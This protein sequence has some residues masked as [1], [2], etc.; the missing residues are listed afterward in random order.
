MN[1][2]ERDIRVIKDIAL[3]HVLSRDQLL[4]LGYF[5]SVS[6]CNRRMAWLASEGFVNVLTTPFFSQHLYAH[7]PKCRNVVGER[8]SALLS[9]RSSSPRYLRHSLAVNEV[10]I[11]LTEKM[12]GTW[13]FEQQLWQDFSW[14]GTLHQVRPDGLV[15]VE[16]SVTFV[17]VDLGHVA[18][19]KFA[20]KLRSYHTF[21][22]SGIFEA[23]YECSQ[24]SL[25][26]VT[27]TQERKH[28]LARLAPN[29]FECVFK[30]FEDLGIAAPGGWS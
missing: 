6:R 16:A 24:F 29:S 17:E 9:G 25:I 15:K 3:S 8:I 5:S 1:I 14:G 20:K 4:R 27:T 7:G 18:P 23:S 11:A 12:S 30:T 10:R 26:T 2:T 13:K 22:L 19:T 28:R 21:Q